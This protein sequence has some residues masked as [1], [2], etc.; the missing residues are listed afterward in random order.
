MAL[1]GISK[2]HYLWAVLCAIGYWGLIVPGV[3]MALGIGGIIALW[4][5]L[6]I[7]GIVGMWMWVPKSPVTNKVI[8]VWVA[9]CIVGLAINGLQFT[10][11]L[12]IP[13]VNYGFVWLLVTA[14]GFAATG[15]LWGKAK[16]AYFAGAALNLLVLVGTF[17]AKDFVGPNMFALLGI[18]TVL[19]LAYAGMKN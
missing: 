18:A 3:M 13:G 11:V 17:V 10:K 4:M 7:I 2:S 15:M 1:N 12:S 6:S 9:V 5:V 14:I 16:E 19:P 8:Y